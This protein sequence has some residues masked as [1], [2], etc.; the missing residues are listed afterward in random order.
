ML[1]GTHTACRRPGRFDAVEVDSLGEKT[2]VCEVVASGAERVLKV[3]HRDHGHWR[4]H[5][6]L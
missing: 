6:H 2:D 4:H 3:F 5:S 1:A